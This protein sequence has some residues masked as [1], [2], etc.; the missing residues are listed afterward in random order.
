MANLRRTKLKA[1]RAGCNPVEI[2]KCVLVEEVYKI[3]SELH[4]GGLV[5]DLSE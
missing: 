5:D 4:K 1:I 2:N 3:I